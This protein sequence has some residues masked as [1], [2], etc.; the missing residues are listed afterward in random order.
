[1]GQS[2]DFKG[3]TVKP[4]TD[5]TTPAIQAAGK[6]TPGPNPPTMLG[7]PS[8]D[9]APGESK[10]HKLLQILSSGLPGA[11]AGRAAQEQMI[12][13]TGGRRAGGIGTGFQA[14]YM[15]PFQRAMMGQQLQQEQAKTGLA[16]AEL[17]PV[18]TP[19]G[20]LP[21]ALAPK[22]LSPYLGMEGK[23]GS[24]QI[25]AQSLENV[26]QMQ[27]LSRVQAAQIGKNYIP[28][29]GV[30]LFD[31]QSKQVI[32]DT[33]I[34]PVLLTP[35]EAQAMGHPELANKHIPISQ[36]AQLERGTA[37][38]STVVQGEAG[39]A[40][41]QR[42]SASP[43]YGQ[44]KPL[45]LGN[46]S[47]GR[48]VQVGDVN[49]PGQTTYM[50]GGQA[51]K[52]GVPGTQ[53]A[54]VQVPRA[55]AKA[56]VPTKIGDTKLAFNTAMAHADLLQKAFD[57]INNG[58]V[59]TWNS[60]KK[61]VATEFGVSGPPTASLIASAYTREIQKMLS[62]NHTTDAEVSSAGATLPPNASPEQMKAAISA[63]RN[64]AQS[65]LNVLNQQKQSAVN[66]SQPNRGNTR[67][68]S[69]DPLGIR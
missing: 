6:S 32:P 56:E 66:Q 3:L 2:G 5:D 13:Q 26:G 58:D 53:S 69:A 1:M 37:F 61:R 51:I 60:I 20:N 28:V 33:A 36:Y 67:N 46:P 15:L 38:G 19:Y 7:D 11:L 45:G 62:S 47:M 52:S 9:K 16:Q 17:Q 57:A 27:A 39:P 22:I 68:Q 48:P 50:T 34:P 21:A 44:V 30:G 14:G 40:L 10:G 35:E 43:N 8:E 24:A 31:A 41:V 54:S 63:Y 29:P 12:A 59:R 65:K 18:Q 23:L 64:L 4:V 55:A 25:R 49:N 42:N